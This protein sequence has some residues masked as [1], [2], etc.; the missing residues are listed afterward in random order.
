M[1]PPLPTAAGADAVLLTMVM[2]TRTCERSR[3]GLFLP[4]SVGIIDKAR[5]VELDTNDY[6]QAPKV[7][8]GW[9][10]SQRR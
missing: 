7:M 5:I 8:G 6:Y 10:G 3:Y 4:T 1:P 2:V 9:L